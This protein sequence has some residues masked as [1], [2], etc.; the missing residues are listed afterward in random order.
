[1]TV[2]S[3]FRIFIM[4][5]LELLNNVDS[6]LLDYEAQFVCSMKIET[7]VVSPFS[8]RFLISVTE[9]ISRKRKDK[10]KNKKLL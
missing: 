6:W 4:N 1:M 8:L 3:F 2:S 7:W 5:F 10:E 9:K